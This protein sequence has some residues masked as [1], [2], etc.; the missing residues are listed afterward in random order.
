MFLRLL[1]SVMSSSVLM[2]CASGICKDPYIA[3]TPPRKPASV[4][5]VHLP[6]LTRTKGRTGSQ[7]FI[8]EQRFADLLK[9]KGYNPL[10]P[11]VDASNLS[12]HDAYFATISEGAFGIVVVAG[13]TLV[14]NGWGEIYL[15]KKVDGKMVSM[16]I[17]PSPGG[18]NDTL[19]KAFEGLPNCASGAN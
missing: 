17:V 13:T 15:F 10:A 6:F 4:C 16:A 2:A 9:A 18:Y 14:E 5:D 3:N 11:A 1:L 12:G 19:F 7:N 8:V